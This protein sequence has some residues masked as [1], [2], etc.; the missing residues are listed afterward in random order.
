M[1]QYLHPLRFHCEVENPICFCDVILFLDE[2]PPRHFYS[3]S[4]DPVGCGRS[5]YRVSQH[6]SVWR[7]D[8]PYCLPVICVSRATRPCSPTY[9][10]VWLCFRCSPN[11]FHEIHISYH[12]TYT[13]LRNPPENGRLQRGGVDSFGKAGSPRCPDGYA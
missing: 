10:F 9:L 6:S 8:V 12:N 3:R 2:P 13:C 7:C 1:L 11:L 5:T 4:R